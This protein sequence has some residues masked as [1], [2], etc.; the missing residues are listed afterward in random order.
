MER[1]KVAEMIEFEDNLAPIT[2][3]TE[4]QVRNSLPFSDDGLNGLKV[5]NNDGTSDIV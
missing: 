1:R 2:C 5:V 4:L 3:E